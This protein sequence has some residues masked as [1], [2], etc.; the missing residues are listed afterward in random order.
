MNSFARFQS[1]FIDPKIFAIRFIIEELEAV[2]HW[3]D[4]LQ[5]PETQVPQLTPGQLYLS[6]P[7]N[8]PVQSG[9][10]LATQ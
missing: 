5:V 4:E 1:L 2:T 3:P 9:T 10:Q 6:G 8:L 7:Q